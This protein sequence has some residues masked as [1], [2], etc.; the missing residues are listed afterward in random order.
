MK[1]D[2]FEAVINDLAKDVM[3]AQRLV[4]DAALRDHALAHSASCARCASRLTDERALS[5]GLRFVAGT[6]NEEAPARVEAAL[7]EAFRQQRAALPSVVPAR[8][9]GLRPKE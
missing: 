9:A 8:T 3:P 2:G 5:S 6:A 7:L 1:C 4:M